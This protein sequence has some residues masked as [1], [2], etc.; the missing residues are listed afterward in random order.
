M[1]K[2]AGQ[3]VREGGFEPPRLAAPPPQDGVSANS[4]TPA[5]Q[6][7]NY[8][9]RGA[10]ATVYPSI[11][12]GRV[13]HGEV[14]G[15]DS[16]GWV[17]AGG[18]CCCELLGAACPLG[19]GGWGG[20]TGVTVTLGWPCGVGAAGVAA[21]GGVA[22]ETPG[23]C[24]GCVGL[25]GMTCT[26]GWLG[27]PGRVGGNGCGLVAAAFSPLNTE[28]PLPR[29]RLESMESVSDVTM[30]TAASTVVVLDK[31]V[32]VPRGPKAVWLPMPPKAPA[33]S[34]PRALCNNTTRTRTRA[35]K[36]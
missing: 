33:K 24:G 13:A 16:F 2:S 27:G 19:E 23:S 32:A 31:N 21:P 1:G 25:T 9:R 6:G 30:N 17:C 15:G 36:T 7:T 4:T 12:P 14:P 3:L 8:G 11:L 22:A 26:L 20:A 35:T 18:V 5:G 10:R 34:V 28:P 29:Y